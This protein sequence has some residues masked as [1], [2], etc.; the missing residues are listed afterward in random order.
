MPIRAQSQFAA[1]P[2]K[3]MIEH[4]N[5]IVIITARMSAHGLPG[6]PMADVAGQPLVIRACRAA[7]AANP[8]HVLVAT[9]DMPIAEAL[10]ASGGDAM[11][12]RPRTP[13]HVNLAADTLALRDPDGRFTHVLLLDVASATGFDDLA[14]RRSLAGLTNDTVD[15]VATA[16]WQEQARDIAIS[17]LGADRE[18]AMLRGIEIVEDGRAGWQIQPVLSFRRVALDRLAAVLDKSTSPTPHS[19]VVALDAGLKVAV[20]QSDRPA[21]VVDSMPALE[22][23]R[24]EMKDK[25]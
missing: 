17:A 1:P 23:L 22:A 13:G 7:A 21:M 3:P 12:S 11:M 14:L 24:V 4:H 16:H 25:T 15:V 19:L 5:T 20:V 18:V 6:L 10:R 8:G 9:P 2:H